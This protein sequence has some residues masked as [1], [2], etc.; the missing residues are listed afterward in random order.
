MEIAAE[1]LGDVG[2]SARHHKHLVSKY[3]VT[4]ELNERVGQEVGEGR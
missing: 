1:W 4:N 3:F 2:I